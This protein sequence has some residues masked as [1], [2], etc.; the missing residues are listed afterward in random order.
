MGAKEDTPEAYLEKKKTVLNL[1]KEMEGDSFKGIFDPEKDSALNSL[2]EETRNHWGSLTSEDFQNMRQG[3][4]H[5]AICK[6]LQN[7]LWANA[8]QKRAESELM[9]IGNI[10]TQSDNSQI[11]ANE[12]FTMSRKDFS[13]TQKFFL[14][15]AAITIRRQEISS[16]KKTLTQIMHCLEIIPKE[17]HI[18]KV[19]LKNYRSSKHALFHQDGQD[20]CCFIITDKGQ[21]TPLYLITPYE[22]GP[23]ISLSPSKTPTTLEFTRHI[24]KISPAPYFL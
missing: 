22:H 20:I 3:R 24:H 4:I 18:S 11:Y 17:D 15:N 14:A 5:R 21:R 1:C 19:G 9:P 12:L 13:P 2:V 7:L 8:S 10:F 6:N 23:A 16:Y